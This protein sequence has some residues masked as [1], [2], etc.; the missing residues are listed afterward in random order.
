LGEEN[1]RKKGKSGAMVVWERNE[2]KKMT[3]FIV[4]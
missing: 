3:I 2:K 4:F 1:E